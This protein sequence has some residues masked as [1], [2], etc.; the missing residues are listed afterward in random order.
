MGRC[1]PP[2]PPFRPGTQGHPEKVDWGGA[3]FFDP[4]MSEGRAISCQWPQCRAGRCGWLPTSSAR[5]WLAKAAQRADGA[6]N[7]IFNVAQF[8]DGRAP[9]LRPSRPGTV[10]AGVEMPHPRKPCRNAEIHAPPMAR[11][12]QAAFPDQPGSGKLPEL[13]AHAVEQFEGD[14]DHADGAFDLLPSGRRQAR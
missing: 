14:A 13:R 5:A 2:N 12:S 3:L 1:H 7:S 6:G 8:W 9:D 11:C 4:R 10:Q